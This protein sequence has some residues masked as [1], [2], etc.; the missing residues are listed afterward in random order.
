MFNE[1]K[2]L[3]LEKDF[4]K[5]YLEVLKNEKAKEH[6]NYL[7]GS[8]DCVNEIIKIL[9]SLEIDEEEKENSEKIS[10]RENNEL[11]KFQ[12]NTQVNTEIEDLL[13]ENKN[14]LE[15]EEKAENLVF[16]FFFHF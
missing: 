10:M 16:N 6:L 1:F 11:I 5:G 3:I 2:K 9:E 4:G 12:E 13:I 14:K 7:F 8:T 15:N